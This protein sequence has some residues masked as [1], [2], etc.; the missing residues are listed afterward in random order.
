MSVATLAQSNP[1]ANNIL[2]S[3]TTEQKPYRN[4]LDCFK[5]IKEEE[6]WGVLYRSWWLTLLGVWTIY[7]R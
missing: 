1:V 6:G 5:R 2:H 7:G 3:F 4:V